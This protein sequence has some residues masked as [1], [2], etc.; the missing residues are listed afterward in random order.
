MVASEQPRPQTPPGSDANHVTNA[1][2][3]LETLDALPIAGALK[4]CQFNPGDVLVGQGDVGNFFLIVTDGEATVT[5]HDEQLANVGPGSVIGELSL[6]TGVRRTTTVTAETSMR[7]LRGTVH[8][9]EEMLESD[10]I[11][12]HFT[13]LAAARLA[14]NATAV[15]F[16]TAA[17]QGP[18]S[19]G[20]HGELRPLLPTDRH[21]YVKLLA[22][23]SPQS[24][25]LRFFS[26]AIPTQRL[27]DYF[28][29]IDFIDHFAWVV[30][31]TSTTPHQGCGIA[32]FIRDAVDTHRAEAAFV[33][34]DEYQGKGIGTILLGALSVAASCIGVSTFTAEV[35]DENAAMR[36]IFN[37]ARPSWKHVDRGISQATMSV[38]QA[39]TLVAPEVDA[40]LAL[41]VHGIGITAEIALRQ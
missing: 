19:S 25:Q 38:E 4:S 36:S 5:R 30:L 15:P 14:A 13:H 18:H 21:E 7:C 33:V 24:R 20:F 27:I 16:A 12:E 41:S 37:K 31:D 28:L 10:E 23:L 32:R 40:A 9:F 2:R 3:W 34:T 29:N 1:S 11:R 22:Q 35:L 8:D 17:P 6:L 26:P 39:R